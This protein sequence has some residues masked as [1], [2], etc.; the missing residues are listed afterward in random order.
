MP[1]PISRVTA[2]SVVHNGIIEN[3]EELRESLSAEGYVF[4]SDTDTEVIVHL[5]HKLSADHQ[6]LRSIYFFRKQTISRC[7]RH[8]GSG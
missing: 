3:H 6:D 8:G 4:N 2:F 7:L 1:I 5:I